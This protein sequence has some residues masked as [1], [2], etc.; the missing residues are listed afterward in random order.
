MRPAVTLRPINHKQLSN[1]SIFDSGEVVDYSNMRIVKTVPQRKVNDRLTV[2]LKLDSGGYELFDVLELLYRT[3]RARRKENFK[4]VKVELGG[5][6]RELKEVKADRLYLTN[7]DRDEPIRN[8]KSLFIYTKDVYRDRVFKM[9]DVFNAYANGR[10]PQYLIDNSIQ[11]DVLVGPKEYEKFL[12]SIKFPLNKY[13]R[14]RDN[15]SDLYVKDVK[16]QYKIM[17]I[18]IIEGADFVAKMHRIPKEFMEKV[19]AGQEWIFANWLI[20][21]YNKYRNIF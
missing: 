14:C 10:T 6:G 5:M 8:K 12:K 21:N 13:R 9:A 19:M 7:I 11:Y 1:Y 15:R 18:Y 4:D 16:L 3:F 2:T 20:K 17:R